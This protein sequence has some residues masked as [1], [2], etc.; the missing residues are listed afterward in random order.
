MMIII[1]IILVLL[2]LVLM[3][4]NYNLL[5][6]NEKCE[7]IIKSYETYMV[8]FSNIINFSDKKIKEIDAR[9][10]FESDDEIGFFFKQIKFLQDQLNGFKIKE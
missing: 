10:A 5:K 3:F 7:D 1:I 6:K 2:V 8:N 9:G 4:T